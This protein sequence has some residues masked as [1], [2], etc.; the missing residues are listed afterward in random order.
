MKDYVEKLIEQVE[1]DYR[2]LKTAIYKGSGKVIG[3]ETRRLVRSLDYLYESVKKKTLAY[4]LL[5]TG[6][7]LKDTKEFDKFESMFNKLKEDE[8]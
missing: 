2:S 3:K 6:K 8:K 1:N 4:H 5:K 7:K